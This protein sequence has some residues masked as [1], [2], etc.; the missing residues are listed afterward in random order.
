[1]SNTRGTSVHGL[2]RYRR[3]IP[4]SAA[5]LEAALPRVS[6]PL[7]P[8]RKSFSLATVAV[9]VLSRPISAFLAALGG[10]SDSI[11]LS[12]VSDRKDGGDD[13]I[14]SAMYDILQAFDGA[15]AQ[16]DFIKSVIIFEFGPLFVAAFLAANPTDIRSS[17]EH[18]QMGNL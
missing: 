7:L 10:I 6:R 4:V 14:K 17:G 2:T 18:L 3:T 1:M 13:F 8:G 16:H 9:T 11:N 5:S 15:Q 12:S